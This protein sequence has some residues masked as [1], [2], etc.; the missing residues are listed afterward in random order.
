MRL[1]FGSFVVTIRLLPFVS[2]MAALAALCSLGVWQLERAQWKKSLIAERQR[3]AELP[4]VM[5]DGRDA[6][7]ANYRRA[8]TTG[9]SIPHAEILLAR[10]DLH[11]GAAGYHVVVPFRLLDGSV[12]LVNR[13][14]IPLAWS[15]QTRHYDGRTQT[16][17]GI[18]RSQTKPNFFTPRNDAHNEFWFTIDTDAMLR[19]HGLSDGLNFYLDEARR[20][21][22][23]EGDPIGGQTLMILRDHHVSYAITWFSLALAVLALSLMAAVRRN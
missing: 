3:F 18:V 21:S 8:R 17:E 23:Q 13:G 5:I 9:S 4:P 2:V 15:A 19:H 10:G 7:L 6:Q 1:W 16:I 20:P 22:Q 14:F 11:S 12:L